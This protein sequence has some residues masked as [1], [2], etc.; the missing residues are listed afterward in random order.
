M[1]DL[2]RLSVQMEAVEEGFRE[3]Q[4]GEHAH[5][6]SYRSTDVGHMKQHKMV[7]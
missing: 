3:R 7:K 5:T 6:A 4:L 1:V 2:V